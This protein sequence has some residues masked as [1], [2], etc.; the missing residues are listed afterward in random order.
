VEVEEK[1][2]KQLYFAFFPQKEFTFPR[3]QQRW[4]KKKSSKETF[5]DA[6]REEVRGEVMGRG[7]REKI[8]FNFLAPADSSFS[9]QKLLK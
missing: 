5:V 6:Q 1:L 4:Q 9:S 3:L 2:L 7:E 8:N